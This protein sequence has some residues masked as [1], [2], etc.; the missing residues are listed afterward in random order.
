M[1]RIA[2]LHLWSALYCCVLISLNWFWR[3]DYARTNGLTSETIGLVGGAFLISLM[4]VVV[5]GWRALKLARWRLEQGEK[6]RDGRWIE[7]WSVVLY[8]LPLLWHH[9]ST[10]NW[11]APDGALATS[12]GGFGHPLSSTVFLL[13]IAGLMLAQIR[14]RLSAH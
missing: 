12:S 4:V 10:S 14:D 1:S 9:V 6:V 11:T 8:A 3:T 7:S 5:L 2:K 13:A